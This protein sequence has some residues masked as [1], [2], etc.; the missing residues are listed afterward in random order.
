MTLQ[1][2]KKKDIFI[3]LLFYFLFEGIFESNKNFDSVD[4]NLIFQ[5]CSC[6]YRQIF[7]SMAFHI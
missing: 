1:P 6:L 5:L 7:K 4:K 2:H 3:Y